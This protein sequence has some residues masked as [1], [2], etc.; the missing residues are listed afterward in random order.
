MRICSG[1]AAGML[2]TAIEELLSIITLQ[3]T[4]T[5]I[6]YFIIY[7]P[8]DTEFSSSTRM[9]S[10]TSLVTEGLQNVRFNNSGRPSPR[11]N[12][13]WLTSSTLDVRF[14]TTTQSSCVSA[15]SIFGAE[16]NEP[17]LEN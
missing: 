15:F 2:Q 17:I 14:G 1:A 8:F 13:Q 3:S 10:V 16:L 12:L 7:L 5:V 9:P 4:T 11:I 6:I